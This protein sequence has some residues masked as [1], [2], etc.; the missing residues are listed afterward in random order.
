M[1]KTAK[2]ARQTLAEKYPPSAPCGCGACVSYCLRPGWWTV[3]EA[4]GALD[5]GLGRR[6]MLEMS[7]DGSFAVLSPAFKGC[8]GNLAASLH[9]SRGCNFLKDGL[10]E[11]H[12]TSL[13]PLECRFCHHERRGRGPACHAELGA[14]WNTPVG[15]AL[16]VRWSRETGFLMRMQ[17]RHPG[18]V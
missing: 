16:V 18:L 7:P 11:L 4:T 17:L 2:K 6:M 9:A 12:D 13:Q 14:D 10:C 15:R 3:A 8:E 5:A 1:P